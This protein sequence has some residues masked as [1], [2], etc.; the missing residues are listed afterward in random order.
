M[1]DTFEKR[2]SLS[3]NIVRYLPMILDNND[4]E[5]IPFGSE[6]ISKN[7]EILK[8][9]IKDDISRKNYSSMLIKFAP[10]YIMLDKNKKEIYF[11]EI[12][13]SITPLCFETNR[14]QMKLINGKV[15]LITDIAD[16]DRDAWNAYN[17]LYPR[18][19]IIDACLYNPILFGC[20]FVKKIECLR[21]FK[22]Y[23]IQ[24][25]CNECPVKNRGV[26]ESKRNSESEGSKT[27]HMNYSLHNFVEFGEFFEKFGIK[28]NEEKLEEL[29]NI[30]KGY[31]L[32]FPSRIYPEVKRK[33]IKEL[34]ELG[35]VW[36][37]DE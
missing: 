37:K 35:C 14:K 20:Q 29:L 21:C 7:S 17:N 10:D 32:N 24:Y 18:T 13:S 25:D 11:I 16:M 5:L 19:I 9:F 6:T 26:F 36:L 31:N 33:I 3:E 12:K 2:Y 22:E 15:P 8:D 23:K 27:P 1:Y 34:K 28:Y 30:I 4:V